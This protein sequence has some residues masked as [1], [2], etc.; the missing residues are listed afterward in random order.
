[1]H[2][3]A[4]LVGRFLGQILR[5][6]CRPCQSVA[7]GGRADIKDRVADA[8]GAA[9]DDLLMA[10]DAEAERVDERVALVTRIEINLT[11]YGRDAET[12]AVM[13]D[14]GDD[15]AEQAPVVGECRGVG[16]RFGFGG[17]G[18][19]TQRVQRTDWASAHREDVPDDASHPGG[20]AL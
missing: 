5:S 1:L 13:P 17:D 8:G 14:A 2:R 9:A 19:E 7:S 4:L 12:I 3:A 6:K 11:G 18:A 16:A 10:Q 20:R 15:L